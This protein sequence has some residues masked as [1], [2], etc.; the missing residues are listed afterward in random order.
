MAFLAAEAAYALPTVLDFESLVHGE[1]VGGQFSVRHGVTI[2]AINI[3]EDHNLA[4]AFDS[5][6]TGTADPDLED[7]WI[8]NGN[9]G[10]IP[11][12]TLLG[13]VLII[14]ENNVRDKDNDNLIA[15]PDDEG[16]RPAG[17]IFFDFDFPLAEIGF[18][19]I[20]VEGP[21]E[22]EPD[23][24]GGFFATFFTGGTE[25][26]S[27]GFGDFI[28]NT[29]LF[30]DST[31]TYGNN[32]ANRISPI[33]ASALSIAAFDRVEINFG[34]SAAIDNLTWTPVP[35]T[36]IPEPSSLALFGVAV[37][38]LVSRRRSRGV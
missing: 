1:I 23:V 8:F 24:D 12:G 34:G 13:K 14:S 2:S 4:I 25:L 3:G 38:G 17:S 7:P 33:S 28:D 10:N 18:D 9:T 29:S 36:P 6:L 11:E 22:F 32:L 27:V 5:T 30:F 37:A 31:V 15:S 19:L 35:G 26:A 16:S 21:G 20:D